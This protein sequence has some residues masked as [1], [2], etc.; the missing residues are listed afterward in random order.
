MTE[1]TAAP[2]AATAAPAPKK[3]A[4]QIIEEEIA[5]FAQQQ[6]QAIANVH[7]VEGAIQAANFLLGKLKAEAAKAEAE[8]KKVAGEVEAEVKTVVGE[9]ESKV[10]NIASA[11]KK[12]V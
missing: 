12:E 3:N 6:A 4:I 1:L 8:V 7:A 9:V 11:V 5:H 10:I 2:V